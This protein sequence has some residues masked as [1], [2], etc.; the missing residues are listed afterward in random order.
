MVLRSSPWLTS[1]NDCTG[2]HIG[3]STSASAVMHSPFGIEVVVQLKL[4]PL[5][6]GALSSATLAVVRPQAVRDFGFPARCMPSNRP[7]LIR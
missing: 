4:R 1:L 5:R 7:P 3:A 2:S 6:K